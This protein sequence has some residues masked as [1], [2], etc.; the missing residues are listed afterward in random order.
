VTAC[1]ALDDD[2]VARVIDFVDTTA[3]PEQESPDR[4]SLR[5][6]LRDLE[7][8]EQRVQRNAER[9][10]EEAR[11]KLVHEILPALD[12][13]DRVIAAADPHRDPALL[14]GVRMVRG[15][16]ERVLVR[17]GAE[18]I[19]ATGARF[20]PEIHE[21]IAT[22]PVRDPSRDKIVLDQLQPGYRFAGRVLR[23]ARVT[24]GVRR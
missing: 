5:R 7:A 22:V 11:A 23:P 8:A 2:Y 1:V 13:L 16:L 10:Y 12:N 14:E 3:E 17:Y 20:D 21:A 18:R 15:Q 6:A 4:E 19:D 24:V 9:V